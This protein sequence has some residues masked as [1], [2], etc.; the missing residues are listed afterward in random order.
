[1]FQNFGEMAKNLISSAE[2][3]QKSVEDILQL[4][5]EKGIDVPIGAIEIYNSGIL[6]L[7]VAIENYEDGNYTAA[8]DYAYE[9]VREIGNV[10]RLV[11]DLISPKSSA[12]DTEVNGENG[13]GPK[14]L[15]GIKMALDRAYDY[16]GKLEETVAR[17]EEDDYD[18]SVIKTVLYEA[19][20]ALDEVGRYIDSGDLASAREE[21]IRARSI[22][23]RINGILQNMVKARKEWRA[24]LFMEQ[25]Q[26]RISYMNGTISKIRFNLDGVKAQNF[27]YILN[28]TSEKL[29]NLRARISEDDMEDV[30]NELDD[31]VEE[32]EDGLNELNGG[33]FSIQIKNLNVFEATICTLNTTVERLRRS[34]W[35]ITDKE[36]ELEDAEKLLNDLKGLL[37]EG[38]IASVKYF[39]DDAQVRFDDLKNELNEEQIVSGQ[40]TITQNYTKE[41]ISSIW[42]RL[43]ERKQKYYELKEKLVSL[44]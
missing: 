20:D 7:N 14:D 18:V 37:E 44:N 6:I 29:Q 28:V 10:F 25:F 31:V 36:E 17:F 40:I 21:F 19:L 30:L 33:G 27:E 15:Y 34:G 42:S 4:L 32:V 39:L 1:M 8:V 2:E 3:S 5:E 43:Q 24:N 26:R 35:N 23:G 13:E 12:D 9:A 11:N 22:L 38:E 41:A 16:W